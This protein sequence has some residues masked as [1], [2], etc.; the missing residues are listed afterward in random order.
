MKEPKYC[1]VKLCRNQTY[2]IVKIH[3]DTQQITVEEKPNV[4]VTFNVKD[5][6]FFFERMN[7]KEIKLFKKALGV[8]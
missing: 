4:F 6:D 1:F 8:K 7:K 5:V 2:P 3:Y